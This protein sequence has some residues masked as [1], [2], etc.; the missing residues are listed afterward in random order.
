M[1]V[2][3]ST[4]AMRRA[5]CCCASMAG[6]SRASKRPGSKT[7]QKCASVAVWP[8]LEAQL[9]PRPL[10][11][12][13]GWRKP[14]PSACRASRASWHSTAATASAMIAGGATCTRR[15]TM[16]RPRCRLAARSTSAGASC[17]LTFSA[18]SAMR[19]GRQSIRSGTCA[20]MSTTILLSN[21]ART[22]LAARGPL[23]A[24]TRAWTLARSAATAASCGAGPAV[25]RPIGQPTARRSTSGA[26]RTALSPRTSAGSGPTRRS[27]RSAT[28]R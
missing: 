28:S 21:G 19:H 3:C 14:A 17:L 9:P 24:S 7:T 22:P 26:S 6:T 23:P 11:R 20:H 1:L 10:A 8:L 5:S 16:A 27:A 4:S 18:A 25:R 13:Q 12:R 15:S 2:S